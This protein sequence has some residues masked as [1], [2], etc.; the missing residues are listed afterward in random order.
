MNHQNDKSK[1]MKRRREGLDRNTHV[2][3]GADVPICMH[4]SPMAQVALLH[5]EMNSGFR[6]VPSMG[7][8]S[9]GGHRG[10]RGQRGGWVCVCV[11]ACVC[12]R[13]CV[14]YRYRV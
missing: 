7:M 14:S 8:N 11:R 4:T 10:V 1:T 6:L 3:W 5:T 12:A 13:V 2:C 9:A